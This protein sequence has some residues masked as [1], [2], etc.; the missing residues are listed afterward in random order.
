[1]D[2]LPEPCTPAS[3]R[4]LPLLRL[5]CQPAIPKPRSFF[6]EKHPHN[7]EHIIKLR[8][9]SRFRG[10]WR[11]SPVLRSTAYLPNWFCNAEWLACA[12]SSDTAPNI[13]AIVRGIA[14]SG[15]MLASRTTEGYGPSRLSGDPDDDRLEL[16]SGCGVAG[17]VEAAITLICRIGAVEGHP[18]PR[19]SCV[20]GY[21]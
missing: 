10:A 16:A 11:Q 18:C 2:F 13:A 19:R 21:V 6:N 4:I 8:L 14:S 17:T 1:M 15:W 12:S 3:A 7:R 20:Q 5:H 9:C